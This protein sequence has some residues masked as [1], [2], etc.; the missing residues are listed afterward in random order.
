[1][2]VLGFPKIPSAGKITFPVGGTILGEKERSALKFGRLKGA[3]FGKAGEPPF[4]IFPNLWE[5]FWE[6][7]L[8]RELYPR[9]EKFSS[10][11][12]PFVRKKKKTPL[13]GGPQKVPPN[14]KTL[15]GVFSGKKSPPPKTLLSPAKKP[16]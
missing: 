2:I 11:K 4:K 16:F 1:L 10:L 8:L 12:P 6:N 14:K 13:K 7:P 5:H 3:P 9:G 15:W